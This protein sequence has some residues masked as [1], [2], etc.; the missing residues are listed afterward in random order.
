MKLIERE[1]NAFRREYIPLIFAVLF[2]AGL[3]VAL[4][5]AIVYKPEKK[6]INELYSMETEELP[7]DITNVAC[8]N[9]VS[10]SIANDA[11]NVKVRY[12][13]MDNYYLGKS[14]ELET[15]TNGDGILGEVDEYG[16]ALKVTITGV[17]DNI[18]IRLT[19]DIDYEDKTYK[20]GDTDN[21]IITFDQADNAYVRTYNV[22]VYSNNGDCNNVLYREFRFVL[23]RMN[24]LSSSPVCESHSDLES[25]KVFVFDNDRQE[26]YKSY[27]KEMEKI[28]QEDNDSNKNKA[29]VILLI[30]LLSIVMVAIV[31]GVV[32]IVIKRRR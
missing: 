1:S 14:M 4:V 26:F 31:V 32:V 9:E 7:V 2:L 3:V 8:S 18:N 13:I 25:C 27:E 28:N 23:P 6:L 21:G 15:D 10:K 5:Y 17:T 19:N 30:I 16:Y 12:E 24:Y 11:N 29:G 20:Y 22:R